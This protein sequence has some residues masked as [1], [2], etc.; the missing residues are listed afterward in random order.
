MGCTS[1]AF[2]GTLEGEGQGQGQSGGNLPDDALPSWVPTAGQ[3]AAIS[4]NTLSDVDPCPQYP[5]SW[6][7]VAGQAGVLDRWNGNALAYGEGELGSLV[8]WG[9]SGSSGYN[10]NELYT[11]DIAERTWRRRT[12]PVAEPEVTDPEHCELQDGSPAPVQNNELL[13]YHPGTNSF[14]VLSG[15]VNL[16]GDLGGVGHMFDLSTDTWRRT[17]DLP[18]GLGLGST[19]YDSGRD[20]IW[21]LLQGDA[22]FAFDPKGGPDADARYG[23]VTSFG[24]TVPSGNHT[25][26]AIDPRHDLYVVL[27]V[28][29][30]GGLLVKDLGDPAAAPVMVPSEGPLPTESGGLEWVPAAERFYWYSGEGNDIRTLTPPGA[31]DDWRT[32][33][34]VWATVKVRGG[35]PPGPRGTPIYGAWRWVPAIE[36][37]VICN[38]VE[39]PVFAFRPEI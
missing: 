34:W 17:P 9:G 1:P 18:I 28:I 38:D 12:E 2:L 35:P 37:F 11:Y 19:A 39:E 21:A 26:A 24:E 36:S 5:C 4:N 22:L 31:G 15:A 10:G 27:D 3:W 13:E 8:A 30:A 20:V 25:V 23:S 14:V 7:N 6:S 33:P 16:R 29:G 32:E